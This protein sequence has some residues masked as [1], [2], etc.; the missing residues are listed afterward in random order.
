[1]WKRYIEQEGKNRK[2]TRRSQEQTV[3]VQLGARTGKGVRPTPHGAILS[4]CCIHDY[5]GHHEAKIEEKDDIF[6]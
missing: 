6:D 5:Q 1:M 3:F 2:I 4:N